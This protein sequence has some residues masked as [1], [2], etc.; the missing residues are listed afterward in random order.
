MENCENV[1]VFSD[2][3]DILPDFDS[4][5]KFFDNKVHENEEKLKKWILSQFFELVSEL[6]NDKKMDFFQFLSNLLQNY[7]TLQRFLDKFKCISDYKNRMNY[8]E[9]N[10]YNFSQFNK[11]FRSKI[12]KKLY[13]FN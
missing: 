10:T 2:Y 1:S 5:V 7:D 8:F 4:K 11:V 13:F 9:D 6:K 3:R 12:D